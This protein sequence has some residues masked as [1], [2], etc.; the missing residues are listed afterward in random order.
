MANFLPASCITSGLALLSERGFTCTRAAAVPATSDPANRPCT[1]PTHF[2][3]VHVNFTAWERLR[4]S[5]IA[6]IPSSIAA[7]TTSLGLLVSNAPLF[8]ATNVSSATAVIKVAKSALRLAKSVSAD[9]FTIAAVVPSSETRTPTSPSE[10]SFAPTFE[11]AFATPCCR[12]QSNALVISSPP[13]SVKAFLHSPIGAPDCDR[14]CFKS[15][16]EK[17]PDANDLQFMLVLNPPTGRP[18]GAKAGFLPA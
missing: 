9:T 2:P 16:M 15:S 7:F 11:V 6:K 18:D 8:S 14:S 3:S 1:Y 12:N 10:A 4:F 13:V 5:R 17:A